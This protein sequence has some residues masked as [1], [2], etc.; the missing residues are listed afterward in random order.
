M[1]LVPVSQDGVETCSICILSKLIRN[2]E[3]LAPLQTNW[4]RFGILTGDLFSCWSLRVTLPKQSFSALSP[5]DSNMQLWL[6]TDLGWL[7]GILPAW[8]EC[9][10]LTKRKN[11]WDG[12]GVSRLTVQFLTRY[13]W[14]FLWTWMKLFSW[15]FRSGGWE[16]VRRLR[17][18]SEYLNMEVTVEVRGVE[19]TSSRKLEKY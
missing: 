10:Y 16:R 17:F 2:A 3:R 4:I 8:S 5:G 19:D 7:Q 1:L 15:V 14:R 13:I 12:A 6:R 9:K 11:S 18:G